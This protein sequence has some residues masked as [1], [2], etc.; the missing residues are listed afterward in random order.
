MA[1]FADYP[2]APNAERQQ[3]VLDAVRDGVARKMEAKIFEE[4]KISISGN[5]GREFLMSKVDQ[6][7][8]DIIYHWRTYLV[9]PRL[10]QVAAS[11]YK[12]DSK[13]PE[14]LRYFDSFQLLN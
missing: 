7:G 11:Y 8:S 5:P 13:S 2:T 14:L 3:P 10:Y 12:R 1:S 4:T 6:N 9:G